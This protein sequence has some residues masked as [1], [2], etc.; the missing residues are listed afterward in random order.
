MSV[1]DMTGLR[2]GQSTVIKRAPNDKRGHA[3]WL[4]KCD[5]GKTFVTNGASLRNGHTKSCGCLQRKTASAMGTHHLSRTPLYK[6]WSGMIQRCENPKNTAYCDYGAKGITVCD[7]WHR[8]E[9]FYEWAMANGYRSDLTI[10]RKDLDKGYCPSNCTYITRAEQNRNTHRTHRIPCGN[11]TITAAE[12]ARMAGLSRS[13]VAQ[14]VRDGK[15]KDIDDVFRLEQAI[16][17]G[18]HPRK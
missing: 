11:K 15:V 4:C 3:M 16:D 13:T 9:T 1:K 2:I 5:C 8:F 10:E 18:R 7:E 17:N 14:W 6:A 12:A